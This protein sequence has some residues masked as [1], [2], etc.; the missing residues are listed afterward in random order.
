MALHWGS[1][2]GCGVSK[3]QEAVYPKSL[4]VDDQ[5]LILCHRGRTSYKGENTVLPKCV[6]HRTCKTFWMHRIDW[7]EIPKRLARWINTIFVC[8]T[9]PVGNQ[10]FCGLFNPRYLEDLETELD[11]NS[12]Y[13]DEKLALDFFVGF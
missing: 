10:T 2:A 3:D 11:D 13:V 4:R 9:M 12:K 5:P 7:A 1:L 8:V 6:T